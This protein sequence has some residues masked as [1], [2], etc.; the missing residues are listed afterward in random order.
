MLLV[1]PED[2]TAHYGRIFVAVLGRKPLLN[3]V[4]NWVLGTKRPESGHDLVIRVNFYVVSD[5]FRGEAYVI[6]NF[7]RASLP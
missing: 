2:V 7:F 5:Y 1:E 3:G 4:D 6:A